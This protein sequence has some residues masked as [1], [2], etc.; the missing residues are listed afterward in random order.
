MPTIIPTLE[1]D[2]LILRAHRPDDFD[3]HA[4]M[5]SDPDVTRFIGGTPFPRDQ[6][7]VRF[8]RIAGMWQVMG[9]GFWAVEKKA[10]GE[11]LGEVGF[12][13]LRR[14]LK[15]SLEGTLEAGWALRPAAHGKGFA[16]EAVGAALVWGGDNF[17]D[18][19]ITCMIDPENTASLR[20]A[21]KLGFREFARTEFHGGPIIL[22]ER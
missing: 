13:E 3:A 18:K 5:W 6:A 14:D 9:F 15:P 11:L 8:L 4:R 7:W 2:R 10:S 16:T 22:L 21:E 12:H 19:R 1:T 20:V 17:P